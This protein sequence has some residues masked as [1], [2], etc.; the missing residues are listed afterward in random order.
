MKTYKLN[1]DL[2][3]EDEDGNKTQLPIDEGYA[4]LEVLPFKERLNQMK[5]FGL[6]GSEVK[7]ELQFIQK[8][9]EHVPKMVKELHVKRGDEV[10]DTFEELSYYAIFIP[11]VKQIMDIMGRGI[12]LG[13]N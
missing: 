3:T 13:E 6:D 2:E 4:V 7:D 8:A 1:F 12:P 11:L 10:I 5:Q 9:L